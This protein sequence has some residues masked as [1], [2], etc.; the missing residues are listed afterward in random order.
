MHPGRR[1]ETP[2]PVERTP[3]G[4]GLFY[5]GKGNDPESPTEK[6]DMGRVSILDEPGKISEGVPG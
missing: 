5:V 3:A 4:G 6:Q 1:T 2:P